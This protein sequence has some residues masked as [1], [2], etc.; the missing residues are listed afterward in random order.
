[1][2]PERKTGNAHANFRKGLSDYNDGSLL[3]HHLGNDDYNGQNQPEAEQSVT[4]LD[5][6]VAYGNEDFVKEEDDSRES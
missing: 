2:E 1:M 4:D 5:G 6:K 3:T